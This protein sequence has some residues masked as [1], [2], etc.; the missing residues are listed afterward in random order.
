MGPPRAMFVTADARALLARLKIDKRPHPLDLHE[1][2]VQGLQE[3][4]APRGH[5]K[6]AEPSSCTGTIP[7]TTL[8]LRC[9][10]RLIAHIWPGEAS[11]FWYPNQ[12]DQGRGTCSIT[13]RYLTVP[14]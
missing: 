5:R 14:A 4:V 7:R 3:D 2:L 1:V 11:L 9:V 12:A 6:Y 10:Y 8:T 13:R